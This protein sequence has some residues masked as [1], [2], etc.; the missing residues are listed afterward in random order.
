MKCLF[1]INNKSIHG[2]YCRSNCYT[3][4]FSSTN[5]N[6]EIYSNMLVIIHSFIQLIHALTPVSQQFQHLFNDICSFYSSLKSLLWWLFVQI[7]CKISIINIFLI[8]Y[9]FTNIKSSAIESVLNVQES[10]SNECYLLAFRSWT[11]LSTDEAYKCKS[12]SWQASTSPRSVWLCKQWANKQENFANQNPTL[13]HKK[14]LYSLT[15]II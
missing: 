11:V 5:T 1:H 6:N 15:V 13:Q 3:W 10:I 12:Y 7:F 9:L 4:I 2:I 8:K 14:T